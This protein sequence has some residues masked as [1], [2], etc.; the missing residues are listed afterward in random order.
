M[1]E[2]EKLYSD[3]WLNKEEASK[4]LKISLSTLERRTKDGSI[5]SHKIGRLRR[6][7]FSDLLNLGNN[8]A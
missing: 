5:P 8:G 2:L 1:V 7:R 3:R 4:V 6:Y